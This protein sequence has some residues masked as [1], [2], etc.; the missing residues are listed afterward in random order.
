MLD[1]PNGFIGAT[2]Q[3][4][5]KLGAVWEPGEAEKA[6]NAGTSTQIPVNPVVKIRGRFASQLR[7]GNT[8]LVLEC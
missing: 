4:L 7:Y 1:S 8:E 6:Y 3:A 2:R 5:N